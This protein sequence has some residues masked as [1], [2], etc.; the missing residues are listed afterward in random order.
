MIIDRIIDTIL[1]A[2]SMA[3]GVAGAGLSLWSMAAAR[4]SMAKWEELERERFRAWA[5]CAGAGGHGRDKSRYGYGERHPG[6]EHGRAAFLMLLGLDGEMAGRV[7]P[8][9]GIVHLGGGG[10]GVHKVQ[11]MH[12]CAMAGLAEKPRGL[13]Y[14]DKLSGTHALMDDVDGTLECG[15]VRGFGYRH[16]DE[17]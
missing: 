10:V 9:Y 16:D 2:T 7:E 3:A 4:R 17:G 8:P 6:H 1:M 11:L 5:S 13:F 14:A 15:V 12:E